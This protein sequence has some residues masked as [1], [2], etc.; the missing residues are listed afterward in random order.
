[1][2]DEEYIMCEDGEIYPIHTSSETASAFFT[3]EEE[4]IYG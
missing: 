4:D 3:E 1:M 2:K